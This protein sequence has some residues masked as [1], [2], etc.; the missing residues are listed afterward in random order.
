MTPFVALLRAVNVG[1]TGKLPMSDL[2]AMCEQLGFLKVQTYIASGNVVFLSDLTE[3]EVKQKLEA[4]LQT[5]AGQKIDVFVR[6]PDELHWALNV[7][8]Y[9]DLSPSH[10]VLI[11]L[12]E[13]PP[14][15]TI[16]R[17]KNMTV[18]RISLGNREIYVHYPDGQGRSKLIIPDAKAG[19]ARNLNTVAKLAEMA[20]AL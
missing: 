11:F 14:K 6:T 16:E 9:R 18:E 17:A 15:D 12:D 1:G 4:G 2:K 7:C 5:Y 10:T 19:T 8:P 3:K 13:A 20:S